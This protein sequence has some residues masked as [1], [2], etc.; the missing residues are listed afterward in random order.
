M[1]TKLETCSTVLNSCNFDNEE[2]CFSPFIPT[3]ME[4]Y[5]PHTILDR[6][7]SDVTAI[8][9]GKSSLLNYT[10][11]TLFDVREG[12][13]TRG[14][15]GSLVKSNRRDFDYILL[16]DTEAVSDLVIV[17][18]LG[19]INERVVNMLI[20]C[21]DSL[22]RIGVNRVTQTAVHFVFNQSPARNLEY[23]IKEKILADLKGNK[24]VQVIDIKP[25]FIECTQQLCEKI[26]QSAESTYRRLDMSQWLETALTVFDVLQKFPDL[27]YF[28]DINERRQDQFKTLKASERISDRSRQF[29]ERQVTEIKDLVKDDSVDLHTLIDHII[30]SGKIMTKENVTQIFENMWKKKV[31]SI[32]NK[33]NPEERLKQTIKFV[34]C[35]YRIYEKQYLPDY[36]HIFNHLPFIIDLTKKSNMKDV[37][38][39]IQAWF[40][41]NASNLQQSALEHVLDTNVAYTL[42]TLHSFRYL[43]TQILTSLHAIDSMDDETSIMQTIDQGELNEHSYQ[44]EKTKS[45]T[46]NLVK[47][48]NVFA[49]LFRLKPVITTMNLTPLRFDFLKIVYNTICKEM[50]TTPNAK[51]NILNI[52]KFFDR[53][54]EDAI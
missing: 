17:N 13:C 32:K 53:I 25:A 7:G 1:Q 50:A 39:S 23:H 42:A 52:S 21:G 49:N 19:D 8:S 6:P 43:N 18:I 28:K 37:I 24:S 36:Q 27:T 47:K 45:S 35:N 2:N 41:E 34:Y 12:R 3:M 26:I 16:I 46:S 22:K 9:N 54:V 20:M 4:F 30:E 11:G 33:F 40:Y 44:R 48:S 14:I 51:S 38:T 15:Y 10:F 29:L 5:K 31:H